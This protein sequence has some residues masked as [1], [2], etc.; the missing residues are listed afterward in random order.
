MS[1]FM[2]TKKKRHGSSVIKG[3]GGTS[4]LYLMSDVAAVTSPSKIILP[5]NLR[6]MKAKAK[7]YVQADAAIRGF[8]S[9]Y[10]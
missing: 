8:S 5:I 4:S 7:V 6:L 10:K 3:H 1:G 2:K 9:H